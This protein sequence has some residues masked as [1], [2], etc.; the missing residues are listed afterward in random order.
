MTDLGDVRRIAAASGH[1]AVVAIARRDGTVQASLVS[2][3]VLDDPVDG[4]PGVAIVAGGGSAKLTLLR[5]N[6]RAT[7]V[8]TSGYEWVAVA[9][10]VR[11]C[12]PD[13]PVPGLDVPATLRAIF[14]AAGGT[15]D[16]WLTFDRTMADERRCGIFV[17][18]DAVTSNG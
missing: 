12:G 1:L 5:A 13:D 18:T 10:A 11:Q 3:G 17:R 2:A 9:G 16:D 8:F 7:V 6:P 15:H 14:V 4:S